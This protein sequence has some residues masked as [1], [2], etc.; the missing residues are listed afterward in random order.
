M[1]GWCPHKTGTLEEQECHFDGYCSECPNN[2][3][4][5]ISKQAVNGIID[6]L[7][8]NKNSTLIASPLVWYAI[9]EIQNLPPVNNWIP[10]NEMLPEEAFGCLVTVWDSTPTGDDFE[11]I[12]PYFVG[13]DGEQWND[14]DGN[15]CPFEV[16]AWQPLPQPYK[17]SGAEMRPST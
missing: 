7:F 2:K 6:Q 12:L 3:N 5:T 17:E 16:I 10:C 9:K 11:N 1:T 4:D 14:G 15:Q 13:W 8:Q